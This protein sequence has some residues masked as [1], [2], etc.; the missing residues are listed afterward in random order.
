VGV[1]GALVFGKLARR[2]SAKYAVIVSLCVWILLLFYAWR[3]VH[4]LTEFYIMGAV[5]G[6][7]MGGTQSLS[8]SI[9]SQLVPHG[10]EAEYFS[11]YEVGDKGTSWMGPPTFGIVYTATGSY[12][13]ALL[14]LL[15]FFV[16]G[17]GVFTQADVKQGELDVAK[18]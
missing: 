18:S 8:R 6:L 14:S 1:V 17:L 3:F 5:A 7:V 11:L 2:I 16:L 13:L 10:K 4:T 9:Y 15:V 12:R